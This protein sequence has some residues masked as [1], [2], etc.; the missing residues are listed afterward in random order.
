[1]CLLGVATLVAVVIMGWSGGFVMLG[2]FS[3]LLKLAE[4]KDLRLAELGE[5]LI[6]F[7]NCLRLFPD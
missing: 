3:L 7:H 4:V 2:W 1:V 5:V 6:E